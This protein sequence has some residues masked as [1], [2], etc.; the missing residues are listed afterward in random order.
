MS[1][2]KDLAAAATS[3]ASKI[4]IIQNWEVTDTAARDALTLTADDEGKVC[5]TTT[6]DKFYILIDYSTPTWQE[7]GSGGGDVTGPSSSTD[8]VIAL[9]D[10]TTGKLI[11]VS[12]ESVESTGKITIQEDT[13]VGRL[14]ITERS[15]APSGPATGD[16][17]LDD[18]TNTAST[19]PG[20]RRYN[21]ASWE[22]IGATAGGGTS[23]YS[24]AT[25]YKF[26]Y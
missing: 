8:S 13:H 10:G 7:I 6:D 15:S 5:R 25:Q 1:Y 11:M 9:F 18:G 22:D 4:H 26:T 14:N 19:N 16:I 21:G 23:T 2:H 20:W 17:Y 24:A 12:V 3:A